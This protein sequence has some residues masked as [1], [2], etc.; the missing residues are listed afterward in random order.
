MGAE[1]E[2]CGDALGEEGGATFFGELLEGAGAVDVGRTDI[3]GGLGDIRQISGIE[4]A[5]NA[6]EGWRREEAVSNGGGYGLC[7][8]SCDSLIKC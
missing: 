5:W 7:D 6:D 4:E 2:N 8:G 3:A 1:V